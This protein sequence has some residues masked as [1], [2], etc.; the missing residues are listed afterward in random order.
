VYPFLV[1]EHCKRMSL[2]EDEDDTAG[3]GYRLTRWLSILSPVLKTAA[4][5][6]QV[7]E[8]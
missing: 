2:E 4:A 1:L 3:E 5:R 8:R 7:M 6:V